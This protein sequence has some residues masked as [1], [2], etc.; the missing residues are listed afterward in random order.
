MISFPAFNVLIL[1]P[2]N[3]PFLM[4]NFKNFDLHLLGIF[5]PFQDP[6]FESFLPSNFDLF[7]A[8]D[9]VNLIAY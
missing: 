7:T 9:R 5:R 3:R 8:Q 2:R 4:G 6:D 1:E